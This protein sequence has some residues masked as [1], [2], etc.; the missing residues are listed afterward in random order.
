MYR[1]RHSHSYCRQFRKP[2][3]FLESAFG[4]LFLGA[5]VTFATALLAGV[6]FFSV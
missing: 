4:Q 3:P 1:P 6:I 5:L 2:T